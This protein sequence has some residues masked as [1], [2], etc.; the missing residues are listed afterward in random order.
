MPVL[1]IVDDEVAARI[2]TWA[3]KEGE[4]GWQNLCAAIERGR[5]DSFVS[6]LRASKLSGIAESIKVLESL[7]AA[8]EASDV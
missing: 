5:Q 4:G 1:Y 2:R 6:V 7:Q 3:A 8:E